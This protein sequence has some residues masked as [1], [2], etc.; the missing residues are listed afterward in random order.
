MEANNIGIYDIDVSVDLYG[1][2]GIACPTKDLATFVY[3]LFNGEIIKDTAVFNLIY[4]EIPTNST[5][6]NN[7]YFGLSGDEFQD[8]KAYGHSGFWGTLVLYFPELKTSI[9]VFILEK[10]MWK[11][12]D[13]IIISLFH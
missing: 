5:E 1:G 10:D 12:K 4:T 13:E 9:A 11:I 8:L 2:G 6:S 7:Y 3:K